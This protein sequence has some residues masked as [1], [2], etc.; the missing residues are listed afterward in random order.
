MLEILNLIYPNH[1]KCLSVSFSR[2]YSLLMIPFPYIKL[3]LSTKNP[4]FI[5][6]RRDKNTYIHTHKKEEKQRHV[7]DFIRCDKKGKIISFM[8]YIQITQIISVK[9]NKCK[10]SFKKCKKKT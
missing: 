9:K 1:C 5:G 6:R 3:R 10:I 2:P 4:C 7:V 8:N